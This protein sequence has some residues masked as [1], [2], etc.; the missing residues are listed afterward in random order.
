MKLVQIYQCL[1]DETRLRILNLLLQRPLCVCHLQEILGRTQAQVSQH[2][3]R[4]KKDGLVKSHRHH[5]W[6]IYSLP[7]KRSGALVAHLKCLQDCAQEE[8][9]FKKD[10]LQLKKVQSTCGWI[11]KLPQS[12]KLAC[13]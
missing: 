10:L 6:M 5:N 12:Q 8:S 2:L 9:L 11:D 13:C 7:D 1:C 3:A 4:M